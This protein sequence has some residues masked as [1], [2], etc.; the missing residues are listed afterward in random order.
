MG[1]NRFLRRRSG[2]EVIDFDE[3]L[4]S[5]FQERAL[6]AQQVEAPADRTG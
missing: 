5:W 6:P 4:A 2:G 1:V 3:N